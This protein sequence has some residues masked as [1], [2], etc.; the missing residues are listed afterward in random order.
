MTES[1]GAMAR[2]QRIESRLD[3]LWALITAEDISMGR[4]LLQGLDAISWA[5]MSTTNGYAYLKSMAADGLIEQV[6]HGAAKGRFRATPAG[7]ALFE[8]A[9]AS[10]NWMHPGRRT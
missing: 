9:R 10:G 8:E 6:D 5:E 2:Q 1:R 7:R 4:V 3:L